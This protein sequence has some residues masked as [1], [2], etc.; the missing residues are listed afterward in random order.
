MKHGRKDPWR[1]VNEP[2]NK[3]Y[4]NC[5]LIFDQHKGY[6]RGSSTNYYLS[7]VLVIQLQKLDILEHQAIKIVYIW[8]PDGFAGWL[9]WH[10]R[11]WFC[12]C[13]RGHR[14]GVLPSGSPRGIPRRMV[15]SRDSP[16][17]ERDGARNTR[18]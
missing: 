6:S 16:W 10:T 7:S 12:I 13:W 17:L 2:K 1:L 8:S 15:M 18:I 4:P 14:V 9:E 5:T 11:L 3:M